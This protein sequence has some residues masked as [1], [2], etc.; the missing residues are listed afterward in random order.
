MRFVGE[1]VHAN[2]D[3]DNATRTV[4]AKRD[5]NT[6]KFHP[7]AVEFE[8]NGMK[9]V[10]NTPVIIRENRAF[11][12]LR[13]LAEGLDLSIQWNNGERAVYISEK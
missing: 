1:A 13:S 6:L 8:K 3:W 9:Q 2:V 12:P 4:I 10:A 7:D 11:V 5:N